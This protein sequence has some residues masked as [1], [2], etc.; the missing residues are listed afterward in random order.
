MMRIALQIILA[1]CLSLF[2][3]DETGGHGLSSINDDMVASQDYSAPYSISVSYISAVDNVIYA[4]RPTGSASLQ[5]V[6]TGNVKRTSDNLRNNLMSVSQGRI[7]NHNTL[8]NLQKSIC[9]YPTGHSTRSQ[10]II[11]L[12][13]LII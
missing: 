1:F 4:P 13:K 3:H 7:I 10:H 6:N 5:R 11:S 8:Y 12:G 9:L 2:V